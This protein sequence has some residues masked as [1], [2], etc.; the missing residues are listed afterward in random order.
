MP[1][2]ASM[3]WS[4]SNAMLSPCFGA[5][6]MRTLRPVRNTF[7]RVL[8]WRRN[9]KTASPDSCVFVCLHRSTRP[10]RVL[11]EAVS[12][13]RACFCARSCRCGYRDCLC[14][15][16]GSKIAHWDGCD[17]CEIQVRTGHCCDKG[18]SHPQRLPFADYPAVDRTA[19]GGL[20]VALI[21]GFF[22][23]GY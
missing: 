4:T 6:P 18:G 13:P 19:P 11:V 5:P 22:E 8:F 7:S 20:S 3:L 16:C 1:E 15:S 10:Y 21:Q 14:G 17:G 23:Q 9:S 12:L 2:N